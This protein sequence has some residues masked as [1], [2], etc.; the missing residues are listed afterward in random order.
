MSRLDANWIFW[1]CVWLLHCSVVG[2]ADEKRSAE[3]NG[4]KTD[5]D[6]QVYNETQDSATAIE[7][8]NLSLMNDAAQDTGDFSRPDASDAESDVVDAGSDVEPDC[9]AQCPIDDLRCTDNRV[10]RCAE[11]SDGCDRWLEQQDCNDRSLVCVQDQRGASCQSPPESC[12]DDLLNQDETSV[13]CGGGT[14]PS[15]ELGERCVENS[16]CASGACIDESC[17]DQAQRCQDRFALDDDFV[18]PNSLL[19]PLIS[20]DSGV[21]RQ[22]I[23]SSFGEYQMYGLPA[24][25]HSGIDIR[26]LQGDYVRVVA[27]GNI[28]MTANLAQCEDGAG[29]SCRLYILDK[30]GRYIYY[31][32]HL[33]LSEGDPVSVEL[34]D[35]ITNATSRGANSYPIQPG[36][37]V[38]AGQTLSAIADFFDNEWAHLHFNIFDASENYDGIN[39]L[40][41][42]T[43]QGQNS[44]IDDEAPVIQQIE[45]RPDDETEGRTALMN[46]DE[47]TG[48][49]DLIAWMGDSFFTNDPAPE[50][51]PGTIDSIGVYAARTLIRNVATGER[52]EIPWYTFNRAP[53]N[54]SGPQRGISCPQALSQ[55]DFFALTIDRSDG[56]PHIGETYADQL[57][58]VS[59]SDSSYYTVETYRHIMTHSWGEPGSWDTTTQP[60]GLYQISVETWDHAGNR[61]AESRFV[62]VNNSGVLLPDDTRGDVLVRDHPD[63]VGAIPSTLGGKPSWAS[64][65]ILVVPK[66]APV[67]LD[68]VATHDALVAGEPYDVYLRVLNNSCATVQ[69]IRVRLSTIPPDLAGKN[70]DQTAITDASLFIGDTNNPDGLTLAAGERGLLGP[71]EYKP[72]T[73]ELGRYGARTIVAEIDAAL[74][75]REEPSLTGG[76]DATDAANDNN[77]ALRH[78]QLRSALTPQVSFS[79]G[80]PDSNSACVQIV[81]ELYMVPLTDPQTQVIL[82]LPDHPIIVDAWDE[83]PGT[84]MTH[85]PSRGTISW[86]LHRKRVPFPPITLPANTEFVV[87]VQYDVSVDTDQARLRISQYLDDRLSGGI[88]IF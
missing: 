51:V 58:D 8:S 13:D 65:D 72:T 7:D 4:R 32:S 52:I 15:C 3:S 70:R 10:Q 71:F 42:L 67:D 2:C 14:C 60:D 6:G 46:C 24:Y 54:C 11:D 36:T 17:R 77:L 41:A 25:V 74:D 27:D 37:D 23:G 68:T 81:A 59:G 57:F 26:G 5:P 31:Y 48:S 43:F 73:A 49:V 88:E 62:V 19:W 69:G 28:W 38:S 50:S 30:A 55:A 53:I 76:I 40:L 56:A 61:A 35:A 80:N 9:S 78:L 44:P 16:D 75:P 87:E 12:N 63:D 21:V 85:D 34:R 64:P 45:V 20:H 66:G 29:S 39:P 83:V 82:R 86:R 79:F 1:C 22:A 47:L 18:E 33:R 84:T